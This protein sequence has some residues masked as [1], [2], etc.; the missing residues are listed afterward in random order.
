MQKGMTQLHYRTVNARNFISEMHDK[1][2]HYTGN[3][4][5]NTMLKKLEYALKIANRKLEELEDM[6]D[7]IQSN[8]SYLFRQHFQEL[9]PHPET[10]ENNEPDHTKLN[11][12]FYKNF[13]SIG[14]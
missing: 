12:E 11:S 5:I 7:K 1:Y 4:I 3:K 2:T 6:D 8:L 9:T 14:Q 10:I 13:V